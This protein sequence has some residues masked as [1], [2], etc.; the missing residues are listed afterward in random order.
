VHFK[1]IHL[2]LPLRGFDRLLVWRLSRKAPGPSSAAANAT[3]NLLLWWRL[4]CVSNLV[5]DD[6]SVRLHHASLRLLLQAVGPSQKS[7]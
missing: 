1:N 4:E 5:L 7:Q 2:P 6:S 3:F